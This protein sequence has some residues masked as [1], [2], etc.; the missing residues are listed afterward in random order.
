[1]SVT[2]SLVM[3]VTSQAATAIAITPVSP[4]SGSGTALTAVGPVAAN[5]VVGAISVSPAGWIGV[6]TLT[7][8]NAASFTLQGSNL[9]TTVALPAGVYDVSVTATP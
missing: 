1:M 7:G 3:T 4:W 5:T 9:V 8:A 6:L 2:M